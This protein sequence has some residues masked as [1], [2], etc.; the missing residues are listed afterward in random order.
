MAIYRWRSVRMFLILNCVSIFYILQNI[1]LWFTVSIFLVKKHWIIIKERKSP[2]KP[3]QEMVSGKSPPGKLPPGKLITFIKPFYYRWIA[4]HV[5]L[6][7][8]YFKATLWQFLSFLVGY[9]HWIQLLIG[10]IP[11]NLI[12]TALVPVKFSI[13]R[14]LPFHQKS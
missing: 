5:L 3:L 6:I 7:P 4:H 9:D 1:R 11:P 13:K 12:P 14:A 2:H 8:T 10:D